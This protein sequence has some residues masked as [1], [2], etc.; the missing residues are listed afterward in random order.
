M[1]LGAAS[2]MRWLLLLAC[3]MSGMTFGW[4]DTPTSEKDSNIG[5]TVTEIIKDVSC[6]G[7]KDGG[8]DITISG[9]EAPYYCLWNTGATTED[10]AG[11]P[12]GNYW[13]KVYDKH[14][15]QG[16]WFYEIKQPDPI[17]IK[18][19][20]SPDY[21]GQM[22]ASIYLEVSGGTMPYSFAWTDGSVA[23][24][25][26]G[27]AAGIYTVKVTDA[28]GCQKEASFEVGVQADFQIT[29]VV[30]NNLCNGQSNGSITVNVIGSTAPYTFLWSNGATT[31]N[32]SGLQEGVYTVDITD[33]NGCV[34]SKTFTL[35]DPYA[36]EASAVVE[37]N[38]C[39]ATYEG[40]IKLSVSGGVAPYTYLWNTGAI[41][42]NLLGLA[43]GDYTVVITDANGCQITKMYTV[44][45]ITGL[46]IKSYVTDVSCYGE[47]DGEIDIEVNGGERP[48]TYVW[49]T[50]ATTQ[51]LYDVPAGSY[52]VTVTDAKGCK[53]SLGVMVKSAGALS[54]SSQVKDVVCKGENNG[55]IDLTVNGGTAPFTFKWSNGATTEDLTNLPAG[56]YSVVVTDKNG[57]G[58]QGTFKVNDGSDIKIIGE[59]YDICGKNNNGKIICQISGGVAPYTIS[60]DYGSSNN[61]ELYNLPPGLYEVTVTDAKGCQ[62]KKTFEVKA[63]PVIY[64]KETIKDVSCN[65]LRDGS[66]E[67]LVKGGTLPLS[68]KWSH[69]S[70]TK[71]VYNLSA[72]SYTVTITDAVGCEIV[73]TYEV[74]QPDRI[75]AN[76]IVKDA[77]CEGVGGSIELNV[78]GGTAPYT[79]LWSNGATTS[80][81]FDLPVGNYSVKITD[82]EG[83]ELNKSFTIKKLN[84]LSIYYNK[85]DDVCGTSNTGAI[86]LNVSGG[87]APYAY[88]WNTGATTSS[89]TGLA[90]GDYT[91]T[92]TDA[93]GCEERKTITVGL[94]TTLRVNINKK[95]ISC[96]G[97]MDGE[98]KAIVSGGQAP[99]SY[100]WSNGATT[101]VIT[102][103]SAGIYTVE[104]TDSKYCVQTATVEIKEPTALTLETTPQNL[105][106]FGDTNGKILLTVSGG[107]APYTY[108]WSNGAITKDLTSV[109]AGTY[110][111]IVTDSRGCKAEKEETI[112]QPTPIDITYEIEEESCPGQKDGS[113]VLTVSGGK[114]PYRYHWSNGATTKDLINI[115]AGTYK[116][117]VTDAYN[118]KKEAVIKMS[119]PKSIKIEAY[120][121]DVSCTND[122]DGSITLVVTGGTVPYTYLW[123]NG[124][125]T[126]NLTGLSTGV[127]SVTVT[128][129]NA[130]TASKTIKIETGSELKLKLTKKDILCYGDKDGEAKVIVYGG[131]APYTYLWS[132]GET[133]STITGLAV[134]TYSVQVTDAKGCV[135]TGA[136]EIKS[137]NALSISL[138]KTDVTCASGNDGT[139]TTIV[140]GGRAPYSFLWSNGETTQNLSGLTP[141]FY[142]V[143]VIDAN[144]CKRTAKTEIKGPEGFKVILK[145][146]DVTCKGAM[147]GAIEAIVNGGKAPY[148]YLWLTGATTSSISSLMPGV[149]NVT[150]TDAN[151][152]QASNSIQIMEP[153]EISLVSAVINPSAPDV[154][155][156]SINL[157][158]SGGTPPYTYLWSNGATT[159]DLSELLPGTYSV[160]VTDANGCIAKDTV[161]LTT[162]ESELT[163]RVIAI[164]VPCKGDSTGRLQGI[165]SNGVP[166]YKITVKQGDTIIG[167]FPGLGDGFQELTGLPAG[168]YTVMAEDAQGQMVSASAEITEPEFELSANISTNIAAGCESADGILL[169]DVTGGTEPY[170]YQW[171]NGATTKDLVNVVAGSYTLIVTDA[172]Q[173]TTVLTGVV[174]QEN[175]LEVSVVA[176]PIP[177]FGDSTG[178]VMLTVEGGKAPFSYQW[179]NGATTQNLVN[180]PAGT[181]QVTVMDADSCTK[182]VGD[183]VVEQPDAPIQTSLEGM[184]PSAIL[185]TD[186]A[187][188]LT[189]SGGTPPYAYLWSTGATTQD[190]S[191]LMEGQY[192]VEVTDANGCVKEDSVFLVAQRGD[193]V[194]R[195]QTVPVLCKGDSTGRL[196]AVISRGEPPYEVRVEKD[197]QVVGVFTG[198]PD[199]FQELDSLPAGMYDVFVEDAVGAT[200]QASAEI[201]EPDKA[202]DLV[203]E[204][205][206]QT[207]PGVPDGSFKFILSGGTEPYDVTVTGQLDTVFNDLLAGEYLVENLG[208]GTYFIQVI[209]ENGCSE[210]ATVMVEPKE[211]PCEEV[212]LESS[213][214]VTKESTPGAADGVIAVSISGGE[215]PYTYSWVGPDG[216][217]S[218][219]QNIS[220]LV[221]GK[222]DLEV[223]DTNGCR[224]RFSY[225]V[226]VGQT[227]PTDP[228][229]GVKIVSEVSMMNETSPGAY[230]GEIKVTITGGTSP[231][232]Y[233]W[234]GP[235]GFTST[236]QN[237]SGLTA[238]KYEL[239]ITDAKGCKAYCT[240]NLEALPD[241]C[242]GVEIKAEAQVTNE[243]RQGAYDGAIN[244]TLQGNTLPYTYEWRGPRGF[245]AYVEDIDQLTG[246][247]YTL[248]VTDR[249]GC[250]AMFTY[251][252]RTED[253]TPPEVDCRM[254]RME[255][256][257]IFKKESYKGAADGYIDVTLQGGTAPYYYEWTGPK[258]FHSTS[259]DI[260]GL[261][262][263]QY[264]LRVK[265]ANGCTGYFTYFLR[266]EG[267]T[268]ENPCTGTSIHVVV[269][270]LIHESKMGARDGLLEVSAQGG[271]APYYYYWEGPD[272]FIATTARI[273][274]LK[275]GEY[276]LF[277]TDSRGCEAIM[278]QTVLNAVCNTLKDIR[279]RVSNASNRGGQGQIQIEDTGDGMSYE[280]FGPNGFYST[281]L[282]I[283]GLRD[284][285]YTLVMRSSQGCK[286]SFTYEVRG[287]ARLVTSLEERVKVYPNPSN[288]MFNLTL[289]TTFENAKMVVFDASG[290]VIWERQAES[291]NVQVDLSRQSKGMYLL[292]LISDDRSV[293]HK[294][295]ID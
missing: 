5:L 141:G 102:G 44:Q 56:T 147:D 100:K 77:G 26:T 146:E 277:L 130:C 262:S 224:G 10:L 264:V 119:S 250:I 175:N 282:S 14:G 223:V 248:R 3:V 131:V 194:L 1:T 214:T 27:L 270:D 276:R 286:T 192:F 52:F 243:S 215:A 168:V 283:T 31:Q 178:M 152:C 25:R 135:G 118:C 278:T 83:C 200:D 125:T 24:D 15:L 67:L 173:C 193:I 18:G 222:Y 289:P 226:R 246:G 4:A 55:A 21:C 204:K 73:Y 34:K 108:L 149:Y 84:P 231:Y 255:A 60:W 233:S 210:M 258:G 35:T 122:S 236:E 144:G 75:K 167:E 20:P 80:S 138:Q 79:Y 165:V 57:C 41:T 218:M 63:S 29:G 230:D 267:E 107:T 95:D 121:E 38:N 150:V 162:G 143:I 66:I 290:K 47:S 68:F 111:V 180:V 292:R 148:T 12:A 190:L 103:L 219:E 161:T 263:G 76:A 221:A 86:Y 169:V 239:E 116:V 127:Y 164:P 272:G 209:D 6:N 51:N 11:V 228:C 39:G 158:V 191:D 171:S 133:T 134:G 244:V 85:K 145:K 186:G 273:D 65:G 247:K 203:I 151:G 37:D 61:K 260:A 69:G 89:I 293:V 201:T 142:E 2:I 93:A 271:E 280:W 53:A 274:N 195:L 110:K 198:L 30:G 197:G 259:E 174:E 98:A 241:P 92:V 160:I 216:F 199:G 109:S 184:N 114:A 153:E 50:G 132:N 185:A 13:V 227:P 295:I 279:A 32:L 90:A 104:V 166:P 117:I 196:Q 74:G 275:E 101:Q 249:N 234:K 23:E 136:V 128:D 48:Y 106:C 238:G 88:L 36:L 112:T 46:G 288:G 81:V 252:V 58:T 281:D 17:I 94:E 205:Q 33:K 172:N 139:I 212:R 7:G 206:D 245:E 220:G 159:E 254:I 105:K 19:T 155:D 157:V 261:T 181:Y 189:V 120:K 287:E 96:F 202:L 97:E 154:A 257:P 137:P 124:A 256:N 291:A 229:D 123:S 9:G 266:I 187:I 40:A 294:L 28:N 115:G 183:I 16:Q 129:S 176:T 268:G 208:P 242:K 78:S 163:L 140:N 211:T 62:V 182:V 87:K 225:V 253:G 156:G 43:A 240:Y 179:S 64:A 126:K 45:D 265:D 213:A 82:A 54:L 42:K 91:V 269:E 99:Y 113:I 237:I 217:T 59:V 251:H 72:G 188:D 207:V 232:T 285:E 22:N 8:I 177:C 71:N 70:T 170:M 49:N 235:D 284:G